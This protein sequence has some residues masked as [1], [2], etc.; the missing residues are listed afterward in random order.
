MAFEFKPYKSVYVDP[1]RKQIAAMLRERYLGNMQASDQVQTALDEMLVSNFEGDQKLAK[2]LRDAVGGDL[3]SMS[4]RADYENLGLQVHKTAKDFN[5]GYRPLEK[6]YEQFMLQKKNLDKMYEDG[7]INSNT[8]NM[9]TAATTFGYTGLE[10]DKNG[11]ITNFYTARNPVEDVDILEKYADAIAKLVSPETRASDIQDIQYDQ[12]FGIPVATVR[13]AT[14]TETIPVSKIQQVIEGVN[15]DPTVAASI[16]QQVYL[17]TFMNDQVDP[18]TG[19][20]G[21]ANLVRQYAE[22]LDSEI[23]RLN[24]ELVNVK[25]PNARKQIQGLID[26]YTSERDGLVGPQGVIGDP[27]QTKNAAL[28]IVQSQYLKE[29]EEAAYQK[30]YVKQETTRA[31]DTNWGHYNNQVKA[32][33]AVGMENP[34]VYAGVVDVLNPESTSP[35]DAQRLRTDASN[36]RNSS[37]E[38]LSA[39]TG[40]D[41]G[42]EELSRFKRDTPEMG[43][44]VKA[45]NTPEEERTDA[46]KALLATTNERELEFIQKISSS[47]RYTEAI[48]YI[49][50]FKK[51]NS[52]YELHNR[53]LSRIYQQGM[54]MFRTDIGEREIGGRSMFDPDVSGTDAVGAL[55]KILQ[56]QGVGLQDFLIAFDVEDRD[57]IGDP[58]LA[59]IGRGSTQAEREGTL[60][61]EARESITRPSPE[62]RSMA[63]M[64]RAFAEATGRSAEDG[65]KL[66][67]MFQ[68]ELMKLAEPGYYEELTEGGLNDQDIAM[69]FFTGKVSP[70]FDRG[71]LQGA[72]TSDQVYWDGVRSN[73]GTITSRG[74]GI[75]VLQK[76]YD[77][78]IE[79]LRD[80]ADKEAA[81]KQQTLQL[82]G[83]AFVEVYNRYGKVDAA[84]SRRATKEIQTL[85]NRAIVTGDAPVF[86]TSGGSIASQSATAPIILRDI[87]NGTEDERNAAILQLVGGDEDAAEGIIAQFANFDDEKGMSVSVDE[88]SQIL[89]DMDIFSPTE[90]GVPLMA[91]PVKF[92]QQG[93]EVTLNFYMPT[94]VVQDSRLQNLMS[95]TITQKHYNHVAVKKNRLGTTSTSETAFT[96]AFPVS[97]IFQNNP[98]AYETYISQAIQSGRGIPKNI[99]YFTGA[100]KVNVTDLTG[101]KNNDG[102]DIIVSKADARNS[103]IVEYS[104]LDANGNVTT[105]FDLVNDI[106]ILRQEMM[107]ME[108]F[109]TGRR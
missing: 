97:S 101:A 98:A 29:F 69:M 46:Q 37:L 67:S 15:S 36:L 78:S 22:G 3:E 62:G 14:S 80:K 47:P 109:A 96:E 34:L 99:T 38:E 91:V 26:A 28:S 72:L 21:H 19:E 74:F 13:T 92:K 81:S 41:I 51:A 25:Q 40:M 103:A 76:S 86:G 5:K 9:W 94:S 48:G 64:A 43:L 82:Q 58:Y 71:G 11:N 65:G 24:M 30:A 6:N 23:D 53:Q 8:Y 52:D 12:Q 88:G 45:A 20:T 57:L 50:S 93:Q 107:D 102:S 17:R 55:E 77:A 16:N 54:E 105:Y 100:K 66:L 104:R 108:N 60:G 32:M 56:T 87:T 4:Q 68:V 84:E 59:M 44:I 33:N 27:I 10:R 63:R 85:I 79:G 1:Q 75:D 49:N 7:R 70:K 42:M 39:I 2:E 89:Y 35:G 31:Y 61:G 73:M 90:E 83:K 18:N 95:G 106:S